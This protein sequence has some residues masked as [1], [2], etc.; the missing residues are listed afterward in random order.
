LSESPKSTRNEVEANLNS[1]YIEKKE[2]LGDMVVK[3]LE[4]KSQMDKKMDSKADL[5]KKWMN[6]L[7]C[8][9]DFQNGKN[10]LKLVTGMR[11][12]SCVL[13][14]TEISLEHF[15]EVVQSRIKRARRQIKSISDKNQKSPQIGSSSLSKPKRGDFV[16]EE[17]TTVQLLAYEL[18]K[19][20]LIKHVME[21]KEILTHYKT[22]FGNHVN[23]ASFIM[24]NFQH[25]I[26]Y[27][28]A[29][30]ISMEELTC[31][32]PDFE[33]ISNSEAFKQQEL[34]PEKLK[35]L[36]KFRKSSHHQ[37]QKN[38]KNLP[39]ELRSL[40]SSLKTSWELILK[41][42]E[43]FGD[44]FDFRFLCHAQELPK[45][46]IDTLLNPKTAKLIEFIPSQKYPTCLF[47]MGTLQTLA[48]IQNEFLKSLKSQHWHANHAKLRSLKLKEHVV[49]GQNLDFLVELEDDFQQILA[50]V[51]YTDLYFNRDSK[52]IQ[53]LDLL[54]DI[55]S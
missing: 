52:E 42:R 53:D 29:S 39:S 25:Q 46:K 7:V 2:L 28:L 40:Y 11:L 13:Q 45:E 37:N 1:E 3:R 49:S 50:A 18:E 35:F 55:L 14:K 23:L 24:K 27:K 32:D 34:Y 22:M 30:G 5:V 4:K 16:T 19:L 43:E 20:N 44:L 33:R 41:Y 9:A 12:G 48:K 6:R 15:K 51:T 21:L 10:D 38:S 36:K 17:L 47:M 26:S 31:S 8:L 54:S